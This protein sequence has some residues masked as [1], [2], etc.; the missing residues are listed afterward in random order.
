MHAPTCHLALRLSQAWVGVAYGVPGTLW[1]LCGVAYGVPGTPAAGNLQGLA[2]ELGHLVEEQDALMGQ[3]DLVGLGRGAA[4]DQA[5]VAD[6]VVRRSEWTDRHQGL[7]GLP[8]ASGPV[9]VRSRVR[10]SQRAGPATIFRSG[11]NRH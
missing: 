9:S 7:A 6:R 3:A 11:P 10:L 5:R 8:P 4:T 2:V 1:E